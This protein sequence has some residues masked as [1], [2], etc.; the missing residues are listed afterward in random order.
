[1]DWRAILNYNL[2]QQSQ[3]KIPR[4]SLRTS[5]DAGRWDEEGKQHD[6][7]RDRI[8]DMSE[9]DVAAKL[10]H[11]GRG[12]VQLEKRVGPVCGEIEARLTD[13]GKKIRLLE[14][15]C[16]YG[17]ALMELRRQFRDR[18]ELTGT[19]R[20]KAH[21]DTEAMLT[22]ASLQN[23][24]GAAE[25]ALPAIIYWDVTNEL[26]FDDC[27]FDVV[28]SQMCIQYVDDKILLLREAARVL[29][30]DGIA[31]IHTPLHPPGIPAPHGSLLEIWEQGTPL[32][33]RHYLAGCGRQ[34]G[35]Q[36]GYH[37][38]VH[39]SQCNDFGADL[40]LVGTIRLDRLHAAW[41][42]VKSIYRRNT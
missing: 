17:V 37:S 30:E 29:R 2:A 9:R 42:G 1:M 18:I 35:V 26:P 13:P 5:P 7:D 19:N 39:L 23:V 22:A 20:E 15:G 3:L 8:R 38:C 31:M 21:G 24:G 11:R 40:E 28:V 14:I 33:F 4:A 6:H 25:T 34:K 16:G 32:T 27:S 12:L 36:F 41:V 10:A